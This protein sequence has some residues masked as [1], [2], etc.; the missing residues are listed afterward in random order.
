MSSFF[1]LAFYSLLTNNVCVI[2]G[3]LICNHV[4]GS[5]NRKSLLIQYLFADSFL[6]TFSS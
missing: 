3:L 2:I 4:V 6:S 5:K 1:L